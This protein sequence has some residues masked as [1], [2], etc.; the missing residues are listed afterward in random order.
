MFLSLSLILARWHQNSLCGSVCEAPKSSL[1]SSGVSQSVH[2][3]SAAQRVIDVRGVCSENYPTCNCRRGVWN[4]HCAFCSPS[5]LRIYTSLQVVLLQIDNNYALFFVSFLR[6]NHSSRAFSVF[7]VVFLMI[8]L[9]HFI[10]L[11]IFSKALC[12]KGASSELIF[13]L[14]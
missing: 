14:I 13:P 2:I 9:C 1:A 8:T 10:F 6:L 4:L 7:L 5:S 3:V 11:Q 12:S